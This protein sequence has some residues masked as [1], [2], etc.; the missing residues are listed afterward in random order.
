MTEREIVCPYCGCK[1]KKTP[2][3]LLPW[4]KSSDEAAAMGWNDVECGSCHRAFRSYPLLWGEEDH[5]HGD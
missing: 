1:G 5:E 2:H 4:I 3:T